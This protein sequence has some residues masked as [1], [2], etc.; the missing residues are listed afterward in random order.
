MMFDFDGGLMGVAVSVLVGLS[1]G[2][3]AIAPLPSCL[4]HCFHEDRLMPA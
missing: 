2:P 1:L 3:A 4:E